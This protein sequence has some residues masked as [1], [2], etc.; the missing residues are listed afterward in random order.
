M[1]FT[2]YT[3]NC[4]G[5]A[6][7]CS[8]PNRREITDA[9]SLA[10]AV[11]WDNVCGSFKGDYRS[12]DNF[13]GCDCVMLDCDND[14]TEDPD[15]WVKPADFAATLPDVAMAVI[16]SRN[17]MKE[18]N[19][20][21]PRDKFHVILPTGEHTDA[22][23]VADLKRRIQAQFPFFDGNAL[24]A[25]RF[26]FG[27]PCDEKDVIWQDGW[28]T[29]EDVL[30]E[31]DG[32]CL[33]DDLPMKPLGVI[34]NGERNR[35]LSRFAGKV[36]K[37][38]GEC[39]RAYSIFQD[40]AKK[41]ETPLPEAELKTIWGSATKFYRNKVSSA[42]GYVPP[43]TYN[44]PA[45]AP[46]YLK[47][48]DYSDI[49]EAKVLVKEYG[50]E[51]L[52]T[53][54]T[55]IMRYDGRVWV[56]SKQQAVGAMEE[57]LDLQLADAM[58]LCAETRKACED[59]GLDPDSVGKGTIAKLSA[60]MLEKLQAYL[61]ARKYFAFVMKRRDM[62]YVVSA[63]QAAKPMLEISV[64]ELDADPFLLN[65]PAGTLDLRKGVGSLRPH[66]PMD[67]ITKMTKVAPS[68]EGMDLW[69]DQL[70]RTFLGKADTMEYVQET[71]GEDIIGEI[72]NE[73][74][75]IAYGCGSNGKSTVFNSVAAVLGDY[76]GTISADTL[77]IGC[78]RNVKPEIAEIKGKR[79]LI[80]SELEESM[81]LSTSL[82]K[83]LCSTDMI[84]GEK[85]YKDPFD[86][87]P[88]HS[89]VLFTNHLPRVGANDDGIWRRLAVI[90]FNA[91]FEGDGDKKNYTKHLI[92]HAGGA[93]LAWLIEGAKKAI[94]DDF[95]YKLPDEVKE[96]ISSYREDN[97]WFSHFIEACCETDPSYSEKSGEFYKAYR[98]FCFQTG[99]YI[100]DSATFYAA[101]EQAGFIRRRT[102]KGKFIHGLRL[103]EDDDDLL[104]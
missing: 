8:Y 6:K 83:Q 20:K 21:A 19:G 75:T 96:A 17:N 2:L 98:T 71:L 5:N 33:E 57:F 31:E 86:F 88:T 74:L 70:D 59:A 39:D 45:R 97:D 95:K 37:R 102:N 29:I 46:G 4:T 81:R 50:D 58:I 72:E 78:R 49:G 84:K 89:L 22:G 23:E 66:D 77:T 82:T 34:P 56:E 43:K 87:L 11:Q 16:P 85:K 80:A 36:L 94:E 65:T 9:A 12:G 25:T 48:E 76:A 79:L 91:K 30:D 63:L 61:D 40:E 52:Y 15:R 44:D 92:H 100:R 60:D 68:D 18:K 38:Y 32:G 53:P 10:E 101:V 104:G 103:K 3:A 7:N 13:Q 26:A 1:K 51:L 73:R 90:P 55:D 69:L 99:D 28:M 93:I 14:H 47:P 27:A 41:C 67:R 35:T 24:D 42:N 54:A 64:S 62:K